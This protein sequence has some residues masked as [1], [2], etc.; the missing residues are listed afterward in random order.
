TGV[1]GTL[2]NHTD[3]DVTVV[4]GHSEVA[5]SVELHET[6]T[7]AS[8]SMKMQPKPGGFPIPANSM[9]RLEPGKDHLMLMG[10]K[11]ELKVGEQVTI[12]LELSDGNSLEFTAPVK[13]FSGANEHYAPNK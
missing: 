7:D 9:Y 3:K 12:V 6:V 13:P 8:G 1:F 4:G 11:R 5:T 2:M 10:L